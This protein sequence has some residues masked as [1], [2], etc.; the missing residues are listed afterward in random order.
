MK[1]K[2][3]LLRAVLFEK[4]IKQW[5][6]CQQIGLSENYLSQIFH[7]KVEPA[8]RLVARIAQTLGVDPRMLVE[9]EVLPPS[10]PGPKKN[11]KTRGRKK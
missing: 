11:F 8:T 1:I 4:G 6:F 7:G 2:V 10:G 9:S 3:G 5:Q